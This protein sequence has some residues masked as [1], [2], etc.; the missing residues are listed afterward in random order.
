MLTARQEHLPVSPL[1]AFHLMFVGPTGLHP[2]TTE[3]HAYVVTAGEER[4]PIS[5]L[6]ACGRVHHHLV[7]TKK[8]ML[9]GLLLETGEARD[10]HHMC[11][12]LGYGA[13]AICP[14]LAMEAIVALQEDG[15]VDGRKSRLDLIN[16]YI[17]VGNCCLLFPM[18]M[19]T[20]AR[21]VESGCNA[22]LQALATPDLQTFMIDL[23]L[24]PH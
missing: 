24:K 10:V 15:K 14:Y 7:A 4:V 21:H 17:K 1:L 22:V 11:T 2:C 13:D 8:R 6:L 23:H 3:I 9:A 16:N 19:C 18:C 20:S 12:L 5:S